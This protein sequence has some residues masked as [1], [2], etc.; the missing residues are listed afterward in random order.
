MSVH[1]LDDVF[2]LTSE[3]RKNLELITSLPNTPARLAQRA[4]IILLAAEGVTNKAIA[5]RLGVSRATVVLWRKRYVQSRLEGLH[6]VP[7]R[8]T[9]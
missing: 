8:G 7:G 1:K 6:D 2:T 3:E 9:F 5:R 4:Y